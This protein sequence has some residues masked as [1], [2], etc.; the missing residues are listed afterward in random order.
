MNTTK[1]LVE[2][3]EKL[4]NK[5]VLLKE[6]RNEEGEPISIEESIE[7]FKFN[8]WEDLQSFFDNKT[9]EAPGYSDDWEEVAEHV[10]NIKKAFKPLSR[11]MIVFRSA[12]SDQYKKGF[13]STTL[14]LD[15]AKSFGSTNDVI[16]IYLK[17]GQ[18]AADLTY[19]ENVNDID[20][21]EILLP[22][23]KKYNFVEE[24]DNI[25]YYTVDL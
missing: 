19:F 20:E 2:Q 13:T 6:Y 3:L 11:D 9:N 16:G 8:G 5:K 14:S 17:K 23:I 24:K 4:T 7:W 12:N 25:K 1:Q 15:V 22:N 21:E 18:L 10:E